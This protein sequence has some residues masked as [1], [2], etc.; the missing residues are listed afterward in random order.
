MIQPHPNHWGILQR[1][2][3]PIK[4]PPFSETELLLERH[5]SKSRAAKQPTVSPASDGG[6]DWDVIGILSFA[7]FCFGALVYAAYIVWAK[8]RGLP[9]A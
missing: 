1:N 6:A 2:N 9:T 3:T 8:L 7:V 5:C 4:G